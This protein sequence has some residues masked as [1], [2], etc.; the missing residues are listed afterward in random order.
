LLSVDGNSQP[1]LGHAY[2]D[3]FQGRCEVLEKSQIWQITS[4]HDGYVFFA[5]ND[6]LGVYDGVRWEIYPGRDNLIVRS[7]YFDAGSQILYSGAVNQ[8]G[9]WQQDRYGKFEYTMLWKNTKSNSTMEFWRVASPSAH[10]GNIYFQSHQKVLKY[11]TKTGQIT[12]ITTGNSFRYLS[13]TRNN[14]FVQE[15]DRLCKISPDNRLIPLVKADDRIINVYED[16]KGE[17]LLFLEHGGIFRLTGDNKLVSFNS[18]TNGVLGKFKLFSVTIAANGQFLVGTTQNGLYILDSKGAILQ[19][20]GEKEGLVSTTVLSVYS[21]PENN[22][23]MGLDGGVALLNQGRGERFFS[24]SPVIGNIHSILKVA[25]QI[26][27][28]TNQGLYELKSNGQCLLVNGTAGSVWSLYDIGGKLYFTHDMGVFCLERN[29][30]VCIKSGGVTSLIC[31]PVDPNDFVSSDYYGMSYY[32]LINGKLTYICK[33]K[34]Y[35]GNLRQLQF[36][37]Y[38]YLWSMLPHR[39]FSRMTLADDKSK[40][41]QVQNY[42]IKSG[43]PNLLIARLDGNLVFFD[44]KTTLRY[45]MR[46]DNLVPDRYASSIFQLCS[47]NLNRFFQFKNIFWYQSPND[48]GYVTRNGNTLERNSGILASV[49]HRRIEPAVA[50][51]GAD[52]FAIGFQNGISFYKTQKNVHKKLKIRTVEAYGVGEAIY[53]D[54]GNACFRLPYNKHYVNIYPIHLN[55]DRMISYRVLEQ[56][57]AWHTQKIDNELTITSLESGTYTVQLCNAGEIA[58]GVAQIIIRVDRPWFFSNLMIFVYILCMASFVLLLIA[59]FR[60][61]NRKEKMRLEAL[62][63]QEKEEMEKKNLKQKQR[64]SELENDNL[65]IELREKDKQLAIITMNDIK[66]K[67]LLIDL[68]KNI[69]SITGQDAG[70]VPSVVAKQAI[71]KIESELN[72]EEEWE[73]FAHYFNTIFDGLLDRLAGQYPQLKQTDLKL[74]AYLKLNLNNKEIADLLNISYRSVEMAKYRLRKKLSLEPN[75]NFSQLLKT[76]SK[77]PAKERTDNNNQPSGDT[78]GEQTN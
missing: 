23:W 63:K 37:K 48:I 33:I 35:E 36:D 66:R 12:E 49:Y 77:Q 3:S 11:N 17:L 54:F 52:M 44:G 78:T 30:P 47:P 41:T 53:H 71:K 67:N 43:A 70:V 73:V 50:Q 18:A 40:V 7:L 24:P 31:S 20:V 75:D 15:D 38:G 57:T 28:G 42:H 58:G 72:S 34:N 16:G 64:I 45:D 27:I 19:N 26:F 62:R 22:I 25:N 61:K 4:G 29:A 68:K 1:L 60:R 5:S 69:S 39:G 13:V 56:D 46:Q 10:P 21:D 32:R 14:V 55:P 51:V 76:P 6:G 74:C 2:L 8:F 9:K 65:K 59:Y